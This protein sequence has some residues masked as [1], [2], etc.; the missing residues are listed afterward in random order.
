MKN[1]DR[2]SSDR[3]SRLAL[4]Q[5][6]LSDTRLLLEPVGLPASSFNFK[7]QLF[8]FFKLSDA[9]ITYQYVP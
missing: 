5:G 3:S 4:E 7:V 2:I 8:R 9:T 1:T 6:L